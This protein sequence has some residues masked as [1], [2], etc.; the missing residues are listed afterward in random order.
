MSLR[1]RYLLPIISAALLLTVAIVRIAVHQIP[2]AAASERP[3]MSLMAQLGKQVFYDPRL[4]ASGTM[5]CASCHSPAHNFGPA[6][7]LSVQLGGPDHNRQGLRAVPSLEYLYR[8]PGFSI[9]PEPEGMDGV[10]IVK[11]ANQAKSH[12]HTDKIAE[13]PPA[14]LPPVPHG[15]LFWDGRANTFQSQASG[16]LFSPFEMA[17]KNVA[18]A[19]EKL[20]TAPYAHYFVELAGPNIL[21]HDRELVAKAMFAVGRYQQEERAFHPYNSKYDY[22]LNGKAT[23]S[24]QEQAGL[25]LFEDKNKGNCAA[26]HLDK[27]TASGKPPMFTDYEY[28]ALAVPRNPEIRANAAPDYYDLG[29]CGP[30]RKDL[31]DQPQYCGMFL[32]PSLRNVATRKA[33]FHNGVYHNL[34]QVLEFYAHR[35]TNPGDIYPKDT[36]GNILKYN[37]IPHQYWKN[38]DTQDAPFDRHPGEAPALTDKEIK[39]VI[40]FLKTLTDGYKP[41]NP[42]R[43]GH[44]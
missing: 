31:K 24:P 16:P 41:G 7:A 5:S 17:V 11:M 4:S 29:L 12:P 27:K 25:K 36:K 44:G 3:Q 34:H 8:S 38:V 18:V 35:E 42:Y 23:L 40:A 33:F 37:D 14:T 13:A 10:N 43:A 30:I 15:G 26:C 2:P 1:R 6:N 28:E 21:K 32:T 19:A 39:D 9:G 20:R 22:Y